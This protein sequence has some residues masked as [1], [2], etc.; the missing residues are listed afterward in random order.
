LNSDASPQEQPK[1]PHSSPPKSPANSGSLLGS[2]PLR[3]SSTNRHSLPA[4]PSSPVNPDSQLIP[5]AQTSFAYPG[6]SP[7]TLGSSSQPED[8]SLNVLVKETPS[9]LGVPSEGTQSLSMFPTPSTVDKE[10]EV[11]DAYEHRDLV[12]LSRNQLFAILDA[13]GQDLPVWERKNLTEEELIEMILDPEANEDGDEHVTAD[14]V[15]D[16]GEGSY[17]T[18]ADGG[19][20]NVSVFAGRS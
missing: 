20:V 14:T 18:S 7:G 10:V 16:K 4:T 15:T 3:P 5:A 8:S 13:A 11:S 12:R 1:S 2:S 9:S 19:D 17:G 6:A